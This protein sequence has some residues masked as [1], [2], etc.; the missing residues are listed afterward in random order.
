MARQ[1]QRTSPPSPLSIKWRGGARLTATSNRAGTTAAPLNPVLAPLGNYGGPVQTL[2]LLPGSPALDIAPCPAGL[3]TNV[4]GVSRP[5]GASCDAGAFES[6][7]FT[8]SSLTGNGQTAS[9]TTAFAAPV[10]VSVTSA[11]GEPV[12]GG[13]V[14][15][16]ITAPAGGA[17]AA[18]SPTA[19]C[20]V[21]GGTTAVCTV[22]SNGV[23]TSPAFTANSIYGA[24]TIVATARGIASPVV[25]AETNG[26]VPDPFAP[27]HT[28]APTVV[29]E[30]PAPVAPAHVAVPTATG[31]VPLPQ[32]VRH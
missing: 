6:R 30:S 16:T 2:A 24:F 32:P 15:F 18:F 5:Q 13:Q 4:R 14:T 9:P 11:A 7:G 8:A 29:G 25:F 21:T 26:A 19:G 3:T 10:G 27:P 1:S 22:G 31:G 12:A 23:S 17:S 28:T 20:T